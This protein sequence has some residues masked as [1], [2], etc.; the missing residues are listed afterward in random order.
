MD[1]KWFLFS[2]RAIGVIIVVAGLFI[3][4]PPELPGMADKAL[5]AL[6]VLIGVATSV[7]GYLKRDKKLTI[8]PSSA[9]LP[10]KKQ[11]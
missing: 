9:D 6:F 11:S 7:Y 8:L 10:W 5:E 3:D 1:T 4:I 2:R